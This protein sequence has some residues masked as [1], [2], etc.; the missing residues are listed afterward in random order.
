LTGQL[1]EPFQ[2]GVV[3]RFMDVDTLDAAAALPGIEK[4]AVRQIFDR[5]F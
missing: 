4:G 5:E 2:E 3:A 1:D